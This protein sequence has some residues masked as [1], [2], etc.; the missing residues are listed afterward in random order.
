[1][2]KLVTA[3]YQDI[4]LH[5]TED[6]WFNATEA[7]NRFGKTPNDWLALPS[8]V[9]YLISLYKISEPPQTSFQI[10]SHDDEMVISEIKKKYIKTSKARSKDGER[11]NALASFALD[12]KTAHQQQ[13]LE[14]A[15]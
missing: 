15:A 4:P 7:S 9:E 12:W 1:M 6:G 5:F 10:I 11:K 3:N 14:K 2:L 8:T 13:Q